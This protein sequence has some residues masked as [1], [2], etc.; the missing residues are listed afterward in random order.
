MTNKPKPPTIRDYSFPPNALIGEGAYGWVWV[1][2]FKGDQPRA[3]KVF[4]PRSIQEGLWQ[5][6]YEKLR[7]LDE[8]PGIVTL[9]DRGHTDDD[10]LPFVSMRLMADKDDAGIW[11]GRTL[12]Q[13]MKD[14][15]LSDAD[16]WRLVR[17]I[18][19]TLAYIHRKDVRH[20]D[21][22][23]GNI[24]MSSGDEPRP[25]ICDF[26]QSRTEGYDEGEALGTLLYACPDQLKSPDQPA[27][28]WD[29]YSFG[30]TAY[31]LLT[32]KLPRLQGIVEQRNNAAPD[33]F[34]LGETLIEQDSD[35]VPKAL[36][37]FEDVEPSDLPELLSEQAQIEIPEYLKSQE[38]KDTFAIIERCLDLK[39]RYRDMGQVIEAFQRADR[40]RAVKKERVILSIVGGLAAAAVLAMTIA[41]FQSIAATSAKGEAVG[42]AAEA[43]RARGEAV[44]AFEAEEKAREEAQASEAEAQKQSKLAKEAAN[45]AKESEQ[46]AQVHAKVAT[47][48]RV[49]AEELINSMLFDLH[50]DLRPLGR[51]D[52][53]DDVSGRAE[54]YF[55][56]L[57]DEHRDEVSEIA[58]STMLNNR[59]DVLLLQ[60]RAE[61]ALA[62]YDGSVAIRRKYLEQDPDDAERKRDLGVSLERV[63]DAKLMLQDVAGARAAFAENLRIRQDAGANDTDSKRALSVSFAKVGDADLQADEPEKALEAFRSAQQLLD[64][65]AKADPQN[66]DRQRDA[67]AGLLRL[68]DAYHATGDHDAAK[69]AYDSAVASL[70]SLSSSD[71]ENAVLLSDLATT[72]ELK[73]RL[74]V[75]TDPLG[76]T[77]LLTESSSIFDELAE[78][79]PHNMSLKRSLARVTESLGDARAEVDLVA[80][81]IDYRAN[82]RALQALITAGDLSDNWKVKQVVTLY[83][84]AGVTRERGEGIVA[85]SHY[86]QALRTLGEL[87][88]D[89]ELDD[90]QSKW[91]KIIETD[92]ESL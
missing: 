88:A 75:E 90:N 81:G 53:L 76:A 67:A 83:K 77:V 27:K 48:A 16:K 71:P 64:N 30:V 58:H 62:A 89:G 24:L 8:P 41:I 66:L 86:E 32:G 78:K 12:R 63:G 79:D 37:T 65:L 59:G 11:K 68:G 42:A 45:E 21:I 74:E 92:L 82:L 54:A 36:P 14:N 85:K 7:A 19:E 2:L 1:G 39:A 84:L 6:E 20:C 29:V 73:A 34:D 10:G 33:E 9:Y 28:N 4:K 87:Q 47:E 25:V 46:L 49:T 80:A 60:G 3:V 52:L 91:I 50:E 57:P 17:E 18:A 44:T 22:K 56:N 38:E 61:E 26:G 40:R 13:E 51:L 43:E 69:G 31:E 23:P 55:A 70:R 5:G 72:L 35:S 15:S